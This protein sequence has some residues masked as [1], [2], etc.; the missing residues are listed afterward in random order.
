M[1]WDAIISGLGNPRVVP[2][3]LD[4]NFEIFAKV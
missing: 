4:S 1:Y 3:P 2:N